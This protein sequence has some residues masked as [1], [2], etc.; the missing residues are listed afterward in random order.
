MGGPKESV[1]EHGPRATWRPVSGRHERKLA[2]EDYLRSESPLSG[3]V[4]NT[5]PPWINK[6]TPM[7]LREVCQCAECVDPSTLQRRTR[8]TP[9]GPEGYRVRSITYDPDQKNVFLLWDDEHKTHFSMDFLRAHANRPALMMEHRAPFRRQVWSAT[10]L[11]AEPLSFPLSEGDRKLALLRLM[12]Y[13]IVFLKNVPRD[14][15]AIWD[16]AKAFGDVRPTF[17]GQTWDVK[18]VPNSKNVAYTDQLLGFHQDLLYMRNPPAYQILHCIDNQVSGGESAFIDALRPAY[19]LAFS[20][21]D[22]F[23]LL[24]MRPIPFQYVNDDQRWHCN[25]TTIELRPLGDG[26]DGY[27][28]EEPCLDMNDS[29]KLLKLPNFESTVAHINY[30][31]PFQGPISLN[32]PN[33]VF[34]ALRVFGELLEEPEARYECKL[35]EGEAVIFDNR[36]VLHARKGFDGNQGPRWLKG[37]YL[38]LDSVVNTWRRHGPGGTGEIVDVVSADLARAGEEE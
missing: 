5:L 7:W 10:D 25:H 34:D 31:P 4:P 38:D 16:V 3:A 11:P 8:S 19:T 30:S 13:G 26:G 29:V 27:N 9:L 20:D 36:R 17:Y 12:Q 21:P 18:S 35:E 28:A 22:K 33:A 23:K 24:T 15:E 6:F 1:K 2:L 14:G 32:S 37:C